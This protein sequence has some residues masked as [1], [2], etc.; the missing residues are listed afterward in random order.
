MPAPIGTALPF[1]PAGMATAEGAPAGAAAVGAPAPGFEAERPSAPVDD[2]RPGEPAD[3]PVGDGACAMNTWLGRALRFTTPR[4]RSMATRCRA[5]ASAIR[6][7]A[8]GAPGAKGGRYGTASNSVPSTGYVLSES[9][10]P[11]WSP[12]A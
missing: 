7:P 11:T 5:F 10:N 6:S 12:Y 9:S 2:E 3:A 1:V 8:L 4:P